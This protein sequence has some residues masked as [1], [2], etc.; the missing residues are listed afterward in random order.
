[1]S[2]DLI[3]SYRRL[4]EALNRYSYEYYTNNRSL[5]SDAEYDDLYRKLLEFERDHPEIV[6]PSSPSQRVGAKASIKFKKVKHEVPML[7]LENAFSFDDVKKFYDRVAKILSI[8]R[9]EVVVFAEPKIDGLSCSIVYRNGRFVQASTRGNGTEGEDVTENVRRIKSVPQ[10]IS[11]TGD[12]EVRGEIYFLK[13]DFDAFN[14]EQE[15]LGLQTFSNPRNAA[16]GSLRLLDPVEC[17]K[18]PLNFFAYQAIGPGFHLQS[19]ISNFLKDQGFSVNNL[20][21]LCQTIADV[22]DFYDDVMRMRDT[23]DYEIDGVVYKYNDLVG[24]DLLG[25]ATKYPRHSIAHKFPA[26]QVTT[27]VRDILLSIGRSGLVTPVAIL[28]P[29]EVGGAVV[30]KATLHNKSELERQDV[31]ISDTVTLQRAGDVIPQ[32]VGVLKEFRTKDSKPFAFPNLCPV[33]GSQL[34][35]DGPFVRCT[36]GARCRGQFIERLSHMVSKDAFNIEGLGRNN[37]VFLADNGFIESD[38]DIFKLREINDAAP[39]KIRD[40]E[41]WGR[42]SEKNLLDEIDRKRR[43]SFD[44]FIYSLGIPQVGKN[45]SKLFANRFIHPNAFLDLSDHRFPV[46]YLTSINGVGE[47]IA[48]DVCD[49]IKVEENRRHVSELLGLVDVVPADEPKSETG[50]FGG[51]RFVFTGTFSSM[52]RDEAAE[53][54]RRLGGSVSESVSSKTDFVVFGENPGSKLE[55]ALALGVQTL[56]EAAFRAMLDEDDSV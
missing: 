55:K 22:Q 40:F 47:S 39:K 51:K 44:R 33:C 31:R 17:S 21:R 15:S 23:L 20:S 7:S 48:R 2:E 37:I 12:L 35:E 56:D 43:V 8:E 13:S 46:T 42:L 36:S 54:V 25:A 30:S 11:Y 28:D 18:R 19:E 41:G 49:F 38:L 32:V 16:S 53:L 45:I 26:N 9:S 5:I 6:M 29:V 52:K 34:V 10:L 50:R 14:A 3:V 1:M 27:V 24:Q 4:V